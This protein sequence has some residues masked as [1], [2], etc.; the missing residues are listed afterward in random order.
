LPGSWQ[1]PEPRAVRR[2]SPGGSFGADTE[3]TQQAVYEWVSVTYGTGIEVDVAVFKP[4][5][6]SDSG[7]HPLILAL[8]WG[9]GTPDLTLGMV[10]AYWS[11]EASRWGYVVV[12]PS[13]RGLSLATEADEFFPALFSWL[14]E[15]V[16]YDPSRVV[17]AGASTGG[18]GFFHAVASDP[19]RFAAAIGMLGGYS[20]PVEALEPFA[21]KPV[22]LMVGEMDS[23]WHARTEATRTTLEAAGVTPRVN[24]IRGQGHVLRVDPRMFMDWLDEALKGS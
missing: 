9:R 19:A 12:A 6:Y 24:V 8:P 7:N 15:N 5:T 22:W 13:I 17:A 21:G 10:D 18:I 4:E 11:R 3:S 2:D 1:W 14:D 20:D 16:S 23:G